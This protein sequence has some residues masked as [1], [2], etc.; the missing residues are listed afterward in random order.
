MT[1]HSAGTQRALRLAGLGLGAACLLWVA[2][3]LMRDLRTT[4]DLLAPSRWLLAVAVGSIAYVGVNAF[5]A[6]SWW[7]AIGVSTRRPPWP[8]TVAVWGA[9]QWAKYLPSNLLHFVQRQV[10]GRRLGL[11]Q[12]SLAIATLFDLS[13]Q[14]FAALLLLLGGS[15][16]FPGLLP[17][18]LAERP[19]LLVLA[20]LLL[21]LCL[22]L[23]P[24]IF[25]RVAAF[26]ARRGSAI[27]PPHS[28]RLASV[29]RPLALALCCHAAFFASCALLLAGLSTG[30]RT[31]PWLP[32]GAALWG[33]AGAWL[34]GTFTIGA[35][36]GIGVREAVLTAAFSGALG[37]PTAAALALSLRLVT[38]LGDFATALIAQRHAP[39]SPGQS[40]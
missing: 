21:L 38:V 33:F 28:I 3:P 22:L 11:G 6:S 10:L 19:H 32:P 25:N 15:L 9:S 1:R 40:M 13:A 27:D 37:A 17:A 35:P 30:F 12:A 34:L 26:A 2:L 39:A 5:L 36:A 18:A 31:G 29:G 16:L 24:L 7:A 23:W 4:L 8:P 14:T 20:L